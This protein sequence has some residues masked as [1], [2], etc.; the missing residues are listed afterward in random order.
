[1][2]EL[3]KRSYG[4]GTLVA[5]L[6][7]ALVAGVMM[8]G[9]G[10]A[11][12][13]GK[14]LVVDDDGVEC[15]DAAYTEV[16]AALDDVAED[17]RV[18]VCPGLYS[19]SLTMNTHGVT[20]KGE[21][22][23]ILDGTGLGS[24]IGITIDANGV[25]VHGLEIRDYGDEGVRAVG[26]SDLTLRNLNIHDVGSHAIDILDSDD[27]EI[28][29]STIAVAPTVFLGP[30]AIRLESVDSVTVSNVDVDGGF[31]GVNF[32][33]GSCDGTEA[34]TN[35]VVRGSTLANNR[36][37]VLI[38]NSTD[39]TIQGNEIT[40]ADA[41][42]FSAAI[43]IGFL[44]N[45]DTRIAGNELHGNTIGIFVAVSGI[46]TFDMTIENNH[47]HD[48][49]RDG[50]VLLNLHDSEISGNLVEDN[51]GH[52]IALFDSTDNEVTGNTA[53]GNGG[54][55]STLVIF[56]IGGTFD[57]FQHDPSSIPNTWS[58]NTCGTSLGT[59]IDCP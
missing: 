5:A 27:V 39:A 23:A 20:L 55:F 29:N 14:P 50:M 41:D 18:H 11:A 15:P 30:E 56:K 36:I 12:A 47:V 37:G 40:G 25:T 7:L 42:F 54:F 57:M 52:G 9:G 38:A 22:G 46:P 33:C 45:A 49:I 31:I 8:F 34:P 24:V 1:M 19:Q 21:P 51:G 59:G 2:L 4:I 6:A 53:L 44:P 43:R 13:K 28:K 17:G 16:Q 10:Q 58:G 32:A 35:G 3:R 48:N 26:V